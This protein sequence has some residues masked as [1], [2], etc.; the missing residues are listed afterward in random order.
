MP[1]GFKG[2]RSSGGD[3]SRA[4]A[5]ARAGGRTFQKNSR[6]KAGCLNA[7]PLRC[8][9]CGVPFT[10]SL[11]RR[12]F[13]ASP[14]RRPFAAS[15]PFAASP[16]RRPSHSQR[17]YCGVPPIR[18]VP[19]AASLLR[20]PLL[21]RP[22][23][24]VSS[25]RESLLSSG[26]SPA[27]GVPLRR[28]VRAPSLRRRS[29]AAAFLCS[30][31]L[32]SLRRPFPLRRRPLSAGLRRHSISAAAFTLCGGVHS[33]ASLLRRPFWRRPVSAA[34]SLLCG[35]FPSASSLL[36]RALCWGLCADS[37]PSSC[38]QSPSSFC[39]DSS[40]ACPLRGL[41]FY[42]GAL[43]SSRLRLRAS[44][45]LRRPFCCIL[46]SS[47]LPGPFCLRRPVLRRPLSF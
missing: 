35:G 40:K 34:S 41:P 24:G 25:A 27:G 14:L 23:C 44:S 37:L 2:R 10:A 43:A 47:L 9:L 7:S 38:L 26:S 30:G 5:R 17:S 4:R 3:G 13:A 6:K 46:V 39:G 16:L 21:Q 32:P 29:F 20:C 36:R 33:A 19:F 31:V 11:V 12:P 1:T 15:L 22:L 45:R 42:S 18:S 28:L 8:P